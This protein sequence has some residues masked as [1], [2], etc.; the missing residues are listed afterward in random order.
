MR[1]LDEEIEGGHEDVDN[2]VAD[3]EELDGISH[4]VEIQPDKLDAQRLEQVCL[5]P[6]GN[7][8]GAR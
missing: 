2:E 7:D 3:L 6:F 4:S 5:C 8:P 1:R